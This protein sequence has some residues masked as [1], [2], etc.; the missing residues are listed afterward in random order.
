MAAN[1]RLTDWVDGISLN[2]LE[3]EALE[4]PG[5]FR[6]DFS[7]GSLQELE[8]RLLESFDDPEE[9]NDPDRRDLADGV[10]G[11]LGEMLLRLAGGAW[12]W[13]GDEP[14]VRADKA[15]G[16][17][18]LYPRRLVTQAIQDQSEQVFAGAYA[19]WEQVVARHRAVDPGWTPKKTR[20]PGVD[21][22]EM[23]EADAAYITA[24]VAERKATFER[25]K[26]AFGAGTDWDFGPASLDALER[27]LGGVTPTVQ[28]LYA[29]EHRGFVEGAV[30]YFGEALRRIK[31]GA[32]VFRTQD[33][34]VPNA[35]AGDPYVQQSG[36]GGEAV[37]PIVVIRA[38]VRT[39][40]RGA[41]RVRYA[42][43]GGDDG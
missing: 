37:M 32:W 3:L 2:L 27:L 34:Q 1:E 35:Y 42:R 39:G 28:E 5:G 7:S 43:C 24:W 31:G 29:P 6:L 26:T 22:F 4:E 30:W 41:L 21:P 9:I 18:D 25:W 11:Y 19:E 40:Q 13:R 38:F 16:L 14:V 17:P 8:G 10:A 23:T 36:Q 20:T 15:L 33:P 12:R